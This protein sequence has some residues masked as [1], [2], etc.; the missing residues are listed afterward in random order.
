MVTPDERMEIET[1]MN[2]L[3]ARRDSGKGHLMSELFTEDALLETT[4]ARLEG[5]E[6]IHAFFSNAA[7][8]GTG[9]IRHFWSN[10]TLE[11]QPDGTVKAHSYGLTVGDVNG[12]VVVMAGDMRDVLVREPDGWKFRER[13]VTH[14]IRGG[15][16][17]N[18][19]GA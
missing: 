3:F 19:T 8:G 6:A 18:S 9:P 5:R 11:A 17:G 13:I 10:L 1:M 2:A 12:E 16:Q 15:F 4:F 7:H 14:A